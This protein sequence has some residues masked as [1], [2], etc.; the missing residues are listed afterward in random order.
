MIAS[1]TS[2]HDVP[3]RGFSGRVGVGQTERVEARSGLVQVPGRSDMGADDAGQLG[4]RDVDA[5]LVERL[6]R[7]PHEVFDRFGL[8]LL[9]L[10]PAGGDGGRT[11]RRAER[12]MYRA[13]SI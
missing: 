13:L 10:L 6:E 7:A 4:R 2:G 8:S 5:V 3:D 11:H 12:T 1:R 9:F